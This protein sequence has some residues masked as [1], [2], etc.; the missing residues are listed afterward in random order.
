MKTK[1]F[2]RFSS[3]NGSQ[4]VSMSF[5]PLTLGNFCVEYVVTF[6]YLGHI[7][8]SDRKDNDDIQRE[9]RNMFMRTNLLIRHFSKC[10]SAVKLEH[11]ILHMLVTLRHNSMLLGLFR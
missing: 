10:S 9:V 2:V 6:K 7:I 4:S 8:L 5:P 11:Y 1:Q 3:L